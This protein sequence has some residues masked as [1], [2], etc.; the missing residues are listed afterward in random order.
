V[1]NGEQKPGSMRKK[2]TMFL[3]TAKKQRKKVLWEGRKYLKF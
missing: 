2:A 3:F 1:E